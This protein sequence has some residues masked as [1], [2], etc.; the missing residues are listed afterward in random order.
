MHLQ[1][2]LEHQKPQ[3]RFCHHC[4]GV[5]LEMVL[6]A[7]AGGQAEDKPLWCSLQAA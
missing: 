6:T 5:E 3:K 2:L 4:R 1:C 7:S